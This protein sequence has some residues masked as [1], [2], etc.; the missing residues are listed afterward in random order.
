MLSRN[1]PFSLIRGGVVTAKVLNTHYRH[2]QV[3]HGLEI[4]CKFTF[5]EESALVEKNLRQMLL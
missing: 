4:L 5:T 1:Q 2:S 3:G